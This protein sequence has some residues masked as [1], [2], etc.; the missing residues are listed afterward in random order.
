MAI[1]DLVVGAA[2]GAL[3]TLLYGRYLVPTY[4][5]R[6]AR[7]KATRGKVYLVGAGPGDA[8]LL[9]VRAHQ[10]LSIASVVVLD[11]LVSEE[12][13][14]LIPR[15][16]EVIYV[17]KRGGKKDSAKQVDIDKILVQK[18]QD[19]HVV[20]RL[21]GGD[22]MVFGRVYSEIRTLVR[23][24]CA[25]EVVPG[26]SS[27]LAAPAVVNIPVTHKE[28]SKHFLVV[29]LHKPDEMDFN[30]LA[31][32]DTLVILMGTRTLRT[33]ASRLIECGRS[34]DTPVALIHSGTLPTQITLVGTLADI[35]DKASDRSY[36]P[37]IIVVGSVA[38]YA[39]VDAY[40]QDED[41]DNIV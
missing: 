22:P 7:S 14:K 15:D 13:N 37:A 12:I 21:K 36:S 28:L 10:L 40:L 31:K 20:V 2:S 30:V 6:Q 35:A 8:G 1:R 9:T 18:S 24:N 25:F 32:V 26:I 17:G 3:L 34:D 23:A 29:S 33:I 41:L 19:G 16:C 4:R 38:R 27:A 5:L 11:D 39:N